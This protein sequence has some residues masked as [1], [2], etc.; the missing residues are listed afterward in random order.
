ME[1][2][3]LSV[4]LKAKPEVVF[5]AWLNSKQHSL[6]TGSEANISNRIGATFTAWDGYISGKNLEIKGGDTIIQSWRTTE[7]A[8]EDPDSK[9]EIRFE[10]KDGKTQLTLIHTQIP[11]GQGDAYKK[12][13][14]EFYFQ[15]MKKY[16]SAL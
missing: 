4:R 8:P 12:G 16:F 15:P 9:L 6:F 10:E 3:R 11:N 7:F 13:W 2:I 5:E 1:K 14:K